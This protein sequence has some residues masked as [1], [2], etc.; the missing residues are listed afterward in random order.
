ME[1]ME[2]PAKLVGCGP[3]GAGGR[4]P[5]HTARVLAEREANREKEDRELE[6]ESAQGWACCTLRS[7][8]FNSSEPFPLFPRPAGGRVPA[9]ATQKNSDSCMPLKP[10]VPPREGFCPFLSVSLPASSWSPA[11]QY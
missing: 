11:A 4:F 5:Y 6:R 9:L 2:L 7:P 8:S 3:G 10:S 1:P